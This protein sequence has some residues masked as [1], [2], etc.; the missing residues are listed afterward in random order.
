MEPRFSR[1]RLNERQSQFP[2]VQVREGHS[3]HVTVSGLRLPSS[4]TYAQAVPAWI[5]AQ[6][7]VPDSAVRKLGELSPYWQERCYFYELED[8][9]AHVGEL[10]DANTLIAVF[11]VAHVLGQLPRK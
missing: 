9:L 3:G 5:G 4:I 7:C 8:V 6:T 11:R 2:A 10:R 1:W